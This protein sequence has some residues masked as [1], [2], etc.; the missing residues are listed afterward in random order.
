MPGPLVST[1]LYVAIPYDD[2]SSLTCVLY[3]GCAAAEQG[4]NALH[5]AVILDKWDLVKLLLN[6][7]ADPNQ[8]AD[9]SRWTPL[10]LACRFQVSFPLSPTI[11]SRTPL[12]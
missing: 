7:G 4:L 11:L 2:V 5:V 3:V 8:Q 1:E 9:D 6:A 12:S 10:L